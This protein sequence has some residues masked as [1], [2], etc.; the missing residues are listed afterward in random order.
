[1]Q[2]FKLCMRKIARNPLFLIVY[3]VGLS[4]MGVAMVGS[5]SSTQPVG[6]FER[7]E[8]NFALIDRDGSELSRGIAEY[9]ETQGTRMPVEDSDTGLQ[10]AVAKGRVDYIL[11]IPDGYQ[12][13]FAEAAADG[14]D[15]EPLESVYSFV[16]A[17]GALADQRVNNYVSIVYALATAEGAERPSGVDPTLGME[18]DGGA[19]GGS[20]RASGTQELRQGAATASASETE[21]T[22]EIEE[23]MVALTDE[24]L[25]LAAQEAPASYMDVPETGAGSQLMFYLQWSMYGVFAGVVVAVGELTGSLARTDMRR[26]TAVAPLTQLSYNVQV[27]LACLVVGAMAWAWDFGLG[28]VVFHGL[29]ET[30]SWEALAASGC[31]LA[32]FVLLAL[33]VGFLVGKLRFGV[34]AANAVGNIGGMVLSFMGGAW[35]PL[36]LMSAEMVAVAHFLPGYWYSMACQ[37]AAALP[38]GATFSQ[39]APVMEN[40]GVVLLFALAF[41]LVALVLGK[42]RTKE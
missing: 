6:A 19:A 39:I 20:E 11:I 35:V 37:Q 10:D 24:A 21:G 4:F 1:M 5:V 42:V 29:L 18:A 7:Q 36:S 33:S 3:I 15:P 31:S 41:L 9:L 23:A 30:F 32:A 13:D 28:C 12:R 40:L 17:T 26:R 38:A 8:V 22:R 16:A 34:A 25:K 27:A 2:V 14:A